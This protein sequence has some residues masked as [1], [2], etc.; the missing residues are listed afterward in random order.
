MKNQ[1]LFENII[2]DRELT[3]NEHLRLRARL[4]GLS[5]SSGI[6]SICLS[7][8]ELFI[9]YNP[10]LKTSDDIYEELRTMGFPSKQLE[11]VIVP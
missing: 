6:E 3:E 2:A 1:Y 7:K 4:R 9:E 8:E 11:L 5:T 10:L